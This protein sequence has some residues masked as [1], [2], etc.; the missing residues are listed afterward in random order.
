MAEYEAGTIKDAKQSWV[1]DRWSRRWSENQVKMKWEVYWEWKNFLCWRLKWRTEEWR[2]RFY[3]KKLT[4]LRYTA[5]SRAGSNTL[6][7]TSSLHLT[8][9]RC[10]SLL[11]AAPRCTLHCLHTTARLHLTESLLHTAHSTPSCT[12]SIL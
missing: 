1:A 4:F 9:P 8:A 2:L 12:T 5:H 11:H 7:L 3:S 10:T 6:H